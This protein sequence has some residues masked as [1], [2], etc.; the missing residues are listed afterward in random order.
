VIGIYLAIVPGDDGTYLGRRVSNRDITERMR[1]EDNLRLHQE[2]FLTVLDSIEAS[3]YVA[4]LETHEVLFMNK[5]MIEVFG[6]DLTGS[7]CWQ[8]IGN[9]TGP[10]AHCQDHL[11][12]GENQGPD[13]MRSWQEQDPQTRKWY[14]NHARRIK[15]TD[16]RKARILI[17]TDI[18][19]LKKM[20]AE[21]RRTHKME[22]FGVLAGGIAHDFNNIVASMIGFTE[23]ALDDAVHGSALEANLHEVFIAGK[24]AQDL[25]RQILAFARQSDEKIEALVVSSV[26]KEVLKL[27][28]SSIPTSIEI[29]K[30]LTNRSAKLGNPTQVHQIFMNL[31]TN[32]AHAMEPDGGVMAVELQD[33]HLPND[34]AAGLNL[35]PGNYLKLSV[36][37]TG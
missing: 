1:I 2:R 18:R 17:A 31:C 11:T 29:K 8:T 15:W 28:R 4:D 6:L 36:S 35:D 30:K 19:R 10:C 7:I 33:V 3:I 21:L 5:H 34:E 32:A 12:A 24:Q 27:I 13:Q 26:A 16:G 14:M 25:V 20:E 22:A 23:L 37:D 9:A